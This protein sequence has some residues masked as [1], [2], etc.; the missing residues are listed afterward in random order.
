MQTVPGRLKGWAQVS[1]VS[2]GLVLRY[3]F[4]QQTVLDGLHVPGLEVHTY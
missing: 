3:W 2:G 4:I 1:E